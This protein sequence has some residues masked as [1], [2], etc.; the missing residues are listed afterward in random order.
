MSTQKNMCWVNISL[1]LD[2]M[3][4]MAIFFLDLPYIITNPHNSSVKLALIFPSNKWRIWGLDV[5]KKSQYYSNSER[6]IK[7]FDRGHS[8]S[9]VLSMRLLWKTKPLSLSLSMINSITICTSVNSLTSQNREIQIDLREYLLLVYMTIWKSSCFLRFL[10]C[11][12]VATSVE[13]FIFLNRTCSCY[14]LLY[15]E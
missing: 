9:Q 11:L 2:N 14:W 10:S 12:S 13:V 4:I 8:N 1:W 5:F 6:Q 15:L 7:K 3:S